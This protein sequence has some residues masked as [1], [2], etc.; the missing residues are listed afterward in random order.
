MTIDE[1]TPL[2]SRVRIF[3]LEDVALHTTKASCW[4]A[5]K[6]KVYDVTGFLEDH[7][8]GDDLIL[9]Y[10]GKDIEQAMSDADEHEHS[11]SAYEMLEEY[12][13]GRIGTEVHI[14]DEGAQ[15]AA[16]PCPRFPPIL[17]R[18]LT[19]RLGGHGGLPP[20][21]HRPCRRL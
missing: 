6:G 5:R 9:K 20:R 21:R 13:I 3:T 14:V 1:K 19:Y 11:D 2:K 15:S 10:A 16:S 17:T 4:V 18:V 12:V 8:G 7:P